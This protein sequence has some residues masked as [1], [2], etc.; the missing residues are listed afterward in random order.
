ML[1]IFATTVGLVISPAPVPQVVRSAAS[2]QVVQFST[3][4]STLLAAKAN[5][6]PEDGPK[7]DL[8]LDP[9]LEAKLKNEVAPALQK[10]LETGLA[11]EEKFVEKAVTDVAP[12]VTQ[13]ANDLVP[14]L[15]EQARAAKP[16]VTA[17][18]SQFFETAGS[19]LGKAADAGLAAANANLA[20]V[21]TEAGASLGKVVGEKYDAAVDA[22][23]RSKL[24]AA[25][26][27]IAET[28]TPILEGS[29]RT[30]TPLAQK[31]ASEAASSGAVL[32]RQQLANVEASIDGY[33]GSEPAAAA[34]P[35]VAS[36]SEP[37]VASA[38]LSDAE[39]EKAAILAKIA[40]L[41]A[42]R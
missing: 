10:A 22:D 29:V 40:S 26:K 6:F 3:P 38:A 36:A 12:I 2:V 8:K 35:A 37:A 31:A 32:L 24:A 1:P 39:A 14:V 34:K 5:I 27:A 30:I 21:A 15:K 25:G 23:V 19:V 42:S 11:A 9:A 41:E 20:P 28:A 16:Y 33:I 18:A 13:A 7:I 17:A 4:A